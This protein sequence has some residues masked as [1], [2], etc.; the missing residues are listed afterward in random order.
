MDVTYRATDPAPAPQLPGTIR[1]FTEAADSYLQ[2]RG[3]NRFLSPIVE[4]FNGRLMSDIVPFDIKQMS[5]ALYP[6]HSASTQNRQAI[7]PARA[8]FSHAYERGWGPVLRIRNSKEDPPARR[9]TAS[10]AWLQHSSGELQ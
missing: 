4:Q 2:H 3:C 8:V 1:T 6:T 10:Q 9:K 7:T 5:P